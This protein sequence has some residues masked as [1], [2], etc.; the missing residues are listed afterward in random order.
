MAK[1]NFKFQNDNDDDDDREQT[2]TQDKDDVQQTKQ[3][4]LFFFFNPLSSSLIS[5]GS[6]SSVVLPAKKI[7]QRES[8]LEHKQQQCVW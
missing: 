3:K 8:V 1:K 6:S 2:Q 5:L 4:I 7:R